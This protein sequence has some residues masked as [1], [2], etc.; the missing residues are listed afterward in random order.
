[1]DG[2][3]EVQVRPGPVNKP[4]PLKD[5]FAQECLDRLNSVVA[6]TGKAMFGGH[7]F[8][9]EEKMY[10][11]IYEDGLYFRTD[12]ETLAEFEK[13]G[14]K[15]FIYLGGKKP[16]SMPYWHVPDSAIQGDDGFA[17]LVRLGCDAALRAATKK[18]RKR[19]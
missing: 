19:K 16:V 3:G 2:R 17:C 8:W 11:L 18:A 5:P 6:T 7:G 13:L 14:G 15:P 9:H 10:A 1:M 4:K 12:S